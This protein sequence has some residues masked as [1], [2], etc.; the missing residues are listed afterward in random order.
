[1]LTAVPVAAAVAELGLGTE[2]FEGSEKEEPPGWLKTSSTLSLGATTLAM[3]VVKPGGGS[4]PSPPTPPCSPR[5]W[6]A[7]EPTAVAV[8]EL[9]LPGARAE[10][11]LPTLG[12]GTE[13]FEGSEKEGAARRLKTSSTSFLALAIA[14]VLPLITITSRC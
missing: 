5:D 10:P 7:A 14:L 12:L 9:G 11:S 8:V 13:S 1:M 3:T 6:L 2:P 4:S